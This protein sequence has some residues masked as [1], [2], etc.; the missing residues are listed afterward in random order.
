MKTESIK[1]I[2]INI[3][4][5]T[6]GSVL[7]A[8]AINGILIP[9]Q[10]LAGSVTGLALMVH[11][12]LPQ[13]PVGLVYFLLNIPVF[14]LGWRFVGRR[15]FFYSAVGMLIFSIAILVIDIRI[16]VADKFLGALLAGIINGT[17]AGVM[18][19][20][21]GSAGGLDILS[22]IA[23]K[24]YSIRLG[25]TILAF[26][27][28]LLTLAGFLF[29]IEAA[30]YTLI[31]IYVSSKLMDLV[32]TGLNQRKLVMI[33]SP[34]WKEI[35]QSILHHLRRGVTRVNSEGGYTS[36]PGI[37]L[38]SV[39]TFAELSRLKA[40]IRNSDPGAFVVI[41]DTLEIM[42][43]GIGNQPHW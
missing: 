10:F 36:Q 7:C 31:F 35:E 38:Y 21:R 23:M 30:L 29:S 16:P 20:S 8:L 11:F 13:L 28:V 34:N 33:L 15:F 26:N 1:T 43:G 14:A 39:I 22:I 40:I 37:I 17:G 5:M 4:L 42:G 41:T 12:Y 18:L 3:S 6:A 19:R 9:N 24:K 27:A 2:L 32:V 25:S